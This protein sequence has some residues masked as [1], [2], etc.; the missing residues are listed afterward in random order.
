MRSHSVFIAVGSNIEPET[1]VLHALQRLAEHVT[2]T[3]ASTFYWNEPL[4]RPG[5]PMFL[6]GVV[7]ACTDR[8]A[9]AVKYEC[10]RPIETALGRVR[11][12]DAHAPRSIDLDLLLYDMDIIDIEGLRLPDPEIR[13]RPFLLFPLMEVAPDFVLPDT[14]EPLAAL[15]ARRSRASLAPAQ[16]FTTELEETLG[17]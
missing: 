4:A 14:G 9:W 13:D 8:S 3:A 7:A 12:A 16:A 11:T 2:I 17:L 15:A 1:N 5:Q 6:N 10:L